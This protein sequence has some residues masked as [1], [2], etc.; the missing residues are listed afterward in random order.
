MI[1]Q[2]IH[3]TQKIAEDVAKNVQNGGLVCLIGDLGSGKTV[4]SK[5]IAKSLGIDDFSVKSPTYT[6]I[7]QYGQAKKN[8]YHIDL[9]RLEIID[10]LLQQEVMEILENKNNIV[11]IEWADKINCELPKD[12]IVIHLKYI[13]ENSRE[14]LISR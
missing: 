4:M 12:K 10:Q 8:F 1:S 9:Y 11:I 13:D 5:A 3:E 2:S 6:Y 7:R 14:I